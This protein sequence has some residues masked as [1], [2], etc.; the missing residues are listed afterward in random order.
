MNGHTFHPSRTRISP[1]QTRKVRRADLYEWRGRF[2]SPC[3]QPPTAMVY[4]LSCWGPTGEPAAAEATL[5]ASP[6]R[7]VTLPYADARYFYKR[8]RRDGYRMSCVI[9][10]MRGPRFHAYHFGFWLPPVSLCFSRYAT[11]RARQGPPMRPSEASAPI[12]CRYFISLGGKDTLIS[13]GD[14]LRQA[15]ANCATRFAFTP[16][17]RRWRSARGGARQTGRSMATTLHARF[18]RRCWPLS[19]ARCVSY[20]SPRHHAPWAFISRRPSAGYAA[21]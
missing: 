13:P 16:R 6:C 15:R 4:R 20:R 12:T 1:A 10:P 3:R 19:A 17:R 8:I 21:R 2:S 18:R 9:T 14:M 7:H 11:R 5:A